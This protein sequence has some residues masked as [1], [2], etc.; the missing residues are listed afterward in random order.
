MLLA[1]PLLLRLQPELLI[2][3]IFIICG[4]V[5]PEHI[6]DEPE[7]HILGVHILLRVLLVVVDLDLL[8]KGLLHAIGHL[9]PLLFLVMFSLHLL[10]LL[11]PGCFF[12]VLLLQLLLLA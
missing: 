12:D 3:L 4:R 2:V 11:P 6:S 7:V 9:L 1:L 8:V 10:T 5:V